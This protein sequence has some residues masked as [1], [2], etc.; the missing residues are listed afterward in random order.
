[1]L[2]YKIDVIKALESRGI[3]ATT[4]KNTGIFGQDTMT[5]FKNGNT[6]ISLLILNRLCAVLKMQPGDIIA[7]VETEEDRNKYHKN[8]W[9]VYWQS[10]KYV[11]YF[12]YRKGKMLLQN[13]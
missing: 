1:M 11:I 4:A 6:N 8:M 12:K 5:K 10:H 7:F 9:K 3:N 2:Q 13:Q